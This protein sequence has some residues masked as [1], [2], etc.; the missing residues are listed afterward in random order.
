[1]VLVVAATTLTTVKV[2]LYLLHCR[3]GHLNYNDYIKIANDSDYIELTNKEQP[4]C[5]GYLFAKLY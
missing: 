5:Q 3:L 4:V 1:M 2:S